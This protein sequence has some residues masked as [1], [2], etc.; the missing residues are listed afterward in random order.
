MT[1]LKA[2]EIVRREQI[3]TAAYELAA[4]S[5]LRAITIRGVAQRAGLSAGLVLFHYGTKQQLVLRVLDSVLDTTTALCQEPAVAAIEAPPE[6]LLA[7][8]RRE[9]TRLAKEPRRTR[10]FF[11]FWSAGL[12]DRVIGTRMKQ[13]LDRYRDAFRPLAEAVLAADQ[14]FLLGVT[15]DGL[16]AVIVSFIKGCLVQSLI[17]PERDLADF[18]GAAEGLLRVHAGLPRAIGSTYGACP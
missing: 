17:E 13:E 7:L 3:R 12:S 18:V 11:E 15:P 14:D 1:G 5:G 9:L 8:L 6:R 4:E 10:L 2:N 16:S